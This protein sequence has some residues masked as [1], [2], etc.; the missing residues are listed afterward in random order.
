MPSRLRVCSRAGACGRRPDPRGI[1]HPDALFPSQ[2]RLRV[3]NGRNDRS[4]RRNDVQRFVV[5]IAAGLGAQHGDGVG[6]D[7]FPV[8]PEL[9][10][11]GVEEAGMVCGAGGVVEHGRVQG[12]GEE[13]R[14]EDV[15]PAVVDERRNIGHQVQEACDAR[16]DLRGGWFAAGAAGRAGDAGQVGEVLLFGFVEL[17]GPGEGVQPPAAGCA[18]RRAMSAGHPCTQLGFG[19]LPVIDRVSRLAASLDE[20]LVRA[21]RDHVCRRRWGRIAGRGRRR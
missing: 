21:R 14:G 20:D 4:R 8:A 3:L 18:S 5:G 7:A 19:L 2:G 9:A 10:G 6:G 11:A 16:A 17:Q 12:L 15:T 13:V 1:R